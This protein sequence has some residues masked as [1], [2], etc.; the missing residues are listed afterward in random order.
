MGRRVLEEESHTRRDTDRPEREGVVPVELERPFDRGRDL[1][2]D[3]ARD[4]ERERALAGSG[5][6]DDQEDRAGLKVEL[7]ARDSRK[8][9]P[10]IG[11]REI[12]GPERDRGQSGN[13]SRTPARL[14]ARW[15][16]TEP[17]ATMTTAEIAI[18]MP[19]MIWM[20]GST[21]A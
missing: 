6:P 15:R 12:P 13:P 9:G 21:V 19:R 11:D 16:A 14:R 20:S 8:I 17:P 1:E 3:Q 5:W 2:R 10:G 7:D 18:A 4:R